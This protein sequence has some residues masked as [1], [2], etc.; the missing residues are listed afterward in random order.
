MNLF[1]RDLLIFL[2][3]ILF[4]VSYRVIFSQHVYQFSGFLEEKPAWCRALRITLGT[5]QCGDQTGCF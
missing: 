3:L 1:L 4:Q 5:F 2:Y